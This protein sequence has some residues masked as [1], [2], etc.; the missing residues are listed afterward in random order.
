MINRISRLQ[1]LMRESEIDFAILMNARDIYYYSG[2]AQPA[3]LLIPKEGAPLLQVRRAWE[4]VVDEV[5]LPLSQLIQGAGLDQVEQK[6]STLPFPVKTIGLSMDVI[7]AKLFVKIQKTFP[8]AKIVDVSPLILQQRS[9][10]DKQEIEMI[11]KTCNL[12]TYMHQAI[13]ENLRPGITELEIAAHAG[14]A[15]REHEAESVI[16]NRRWDANL[17]PDGIVSCSK[18][19]WKISGSALTITGIGLSPSLAWGAS[20]T[21]VSKGDLVAVDIALNR[22]GYHGDVARTYVVGKADERQQEMFNCIL[23]VQNTV[24]AYIKSGVTAEDAFLIARAKA[25]EL[26]VGQYFQGYGNNQGTYVGHG[27]GLEVDEPPTL[28]LGEKTVLQENMVL[29]VEPKLI[30]PEWG[31]MNN[32]DCFIITADGSELIYTVP[33]QLFEVY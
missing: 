6:I 5:F 33:R 15:M 28:Q 12:Y 8:N 29:A 19:S 16:R 3:N 2:T 24:V 21:V 32:E 25:E 9:V 31:A 17:H 18:T 7:P 27:V 1:Q 26:D 11:K 4:F 14:K 13:M 22:H 10:K 23:E 20:T 30:I